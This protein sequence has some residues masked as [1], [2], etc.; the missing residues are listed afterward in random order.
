M[1]REFF[2][3]STVTITVTTAI[4]LLVL[5]LGIRLKRQDDP[6]QPARAEPEG[7]RFSIRDLMLFTAA[8]A[9]LSAGARA[10][11]ESPRRMILLMAVWALCFVAVGLAA[12]W[13]ALGNDRPLGR[14]PV[15]LVLSPLLGAFFAFAAAPLPMVGPT[16]S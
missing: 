10:L 7:L 1:R 5:S 11:Q 16:S 6:G 13:A 12:L 8:V 3:I 4:L 14:G 9:V 2:G 15:V